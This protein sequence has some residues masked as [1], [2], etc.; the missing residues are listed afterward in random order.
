MA[1]KNT[2][3]ARH[4]AR[5]ALS[6][7]D[8][9][10]TRRFRKP[11]NMQP[12]CVWSALTWTRDSSQST[13]KTTTWIHNLAAIVAAAA[14]A[15]T[16]KSSQP[17]PP[18]QWNWLLIGLKTPVLNTLIRTWWALVSTIVSLSFP[19][20]EA[21]ANYI[22]TWKHRRDD[23]RDGH[24]QLHWSTKQHGAGGLAGRDIYR[25]PFETV[26]LA[27]T[28]IKLQGACVIVWHV[29]RPRVASCW[30]QKSGDPLPTF[31]KHKC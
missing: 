24:R 16:C 15:A 3:S 23:R 1:W 29:L 7:V 9:I 21:K 12:F 28:A 4:F 22:P 2:R 18:P 11:K 13:R 19:S 25:P 5:V 6:R 26:A 20:S 27:I 30:G 14:T 31:E 17:P 10:L 8:M